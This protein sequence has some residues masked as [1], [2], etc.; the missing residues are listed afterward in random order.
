[1]P[2]AWPA[3]AAGWM[4]HL[5][6]SGLYAEDAVLLLGLTAAAGGVE[7]S[8]TCVSITQTELNKY[9]TFMADPAGSRVFTITLVYRQFITS[10]SFN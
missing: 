5:V 6:T 9:Q 4:V 1:M 10:D 3:D 2:T 7:T 8:R